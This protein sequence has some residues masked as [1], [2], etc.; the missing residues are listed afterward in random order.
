MVRAV[1]DR[2]FLPAK[3]LFE[4]VG[5]MMIL[6][7]KTITA[8]GPPALPLR[9][10]VRR[11]VPLRAAALLV[12]D[13]DLH[14]R[15]RLRRPGPAGRQLPHPLRRPRPPRRLLHPRLGPRVRPLRHRDRRRRRRRHRDH[16]RPRRPQDP[17]GARRAAGAR[18]RPDQEPRRAPLPR[19]DADHRA[20]RHLRADLRD[21]RR[22]LRRARLRPAARRLLRH[23]LQQRLGHRPLGLDPQVHDV[24]RRSSRSSAATKG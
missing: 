12:P 6:T 24:R 8:I 21:L 14:G 15:L 1:A 5:N 2:A 17:R 13:D 3:T 9:R 10:R 7:G 18:R 23:P 20:D 19:P 4:Q 11:P 16:R 22:D